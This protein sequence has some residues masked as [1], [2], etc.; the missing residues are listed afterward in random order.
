MGAHDKTPY[1]TLL[2]NAAVEQ[3]LVGNTTHRLGQGRTAADHHG[4]IEVLGFS[5]KCFGK[6]IEFV[7]GGGIH[8]LVFFR[9]S[10]FLSDI[11]AEHRGVI[12]K[13]IVMGKLCFGNGDEPF[14]ILH[15]MY[16]TDGD[17]P[18]F[19][20]RRTERHLGPYLYAVFPKHLP[21]H[22][23]LQWEM[24]AQ[25]GIAPADEDEPVA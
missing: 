19:N 21:H 13:H 16:A 25:T 1:P 15:I 11:I 24:S 10:I 7:V 12:G 6:G 23:G 5:I 2:Q 4:S 20:E 3:G 8:N 9:I 22:V 18:C 14:P 17:T